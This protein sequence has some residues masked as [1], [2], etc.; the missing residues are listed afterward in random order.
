MQKIAWNGYLFSQPDSAFHYAQIIYKMAEEENL[1]KYKAKALNIQGTSL[2]IR[3]NYQ[4]ALQY[5]NRGLSLYKDIGDKNGIAS[6]L[7]S[8]ATIYQDQGNYPKAIEYNAQCLKRFEAMGDN[9]NMA[10]VLNNIGTLYKQQ[11]EVSKAMDYYARC[12]KIDEE[13]N[14]QNSMA[15]TIIN[16]GLIHLNK[17]DYAEGMNKFT[18]ALKIFERFGNKTNMAST[19]NKM[20]VVYDIQGEPL[21]A[22]EHFEKSLRINEE[23]ENN[24]GM[25]YALSNI[26]E[27]HRD[28]GNYAQAITFVSKSLKLAKETGNIAQIKGASEIL[29]PIFKTMGQ[30]KKS[31]EMHELSI[32]M[33]DKIINEENTRAIIQQEYKYEY[34]KKALADSIKNVEATKLTKAQL[35]AQRAENARQQQ[36]AYFLY[37]GLTL[38]LIFGVFI[39]NR[40]RVTNRQKMVIEEQK[41]DITDS[42]QY[43]E[44]IQRA[45]VPT[46]ENLKEVLPD[47]FVLFQPKDIVSGD[48]YW[49]QHH[50]NNVY[51]AV[52]DC[53]GHGVPGAFMSMI[54]SSLLDE[55]VVEKGLAKPNEIFYEVRKGFINALKQTGEKG[56]QKDGMDAVLIS[57]D[58]NNKLQVAVANNPLFLIRKGELLET[59][60]DRQPVGF[61]TGEQKPFTHHEIT[62]EKGDTLYVFS[63]GYHDQFGG[64]KD[65]K[66]MI[67]NFK[68]LLLS[69]QDKSMNE[70]KTILEETMAEWKGD[71]EQIDDILVIGVR[72]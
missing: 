2:G 65:K 28:Q 58:K 46:I 71:T 21:L 52:C 69:I 10:I 17:G 30:Y 15:L 4:E 51:L 50:N 5:Y 53:T 6:S 36:Q 14:D 20:G 23:L 72:F 41:K 16:I 25:A 11:G 45:L 64:P 63:D 38:T 8:I 54:G 59:K 24:Y 67:K 29:H 12:L 27:I 70:Q 32:K 33:R 26:G 60:P 48:F 47:G 7:G 61:F 66:F 13:L 49:M 44:N 43:A 68:K 42:I 3:G 31:L 34:E 56:Q 1:S 55:A 22:K 40:F 37:T 39:F 57:W 9:A 62:L 19:L 35:A 18:Q